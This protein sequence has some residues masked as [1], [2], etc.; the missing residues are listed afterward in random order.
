MQAYLFLRYLGRNETIIRVMLIFRSLDHNEK[1][2]DV[3]DVASLFGS[4][5]VL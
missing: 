5:R 4:S 2:L 1:C 3:A